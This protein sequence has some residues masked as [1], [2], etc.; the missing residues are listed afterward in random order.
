MLGILSAALCVFRMQ[1]IF[2]AGAADSAAAARMSSPFSASGAL[3]K[4]LAASYTK[5]SIRLHPAVLY[6]VAEETVALHFRRERGRR[7][8]EI[9]A[10]T[11]TLFAAGAFIDKKLRVLRQ[12]QAERPTAQRI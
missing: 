7:V 3:L 10:Y 6:A 1:V 12:E 4:T 8:A 11:D 5:Q 2:Y 9:T